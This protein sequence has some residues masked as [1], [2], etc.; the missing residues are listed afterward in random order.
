MHIPGPQAG[1]ALIIVDLQNDFLPGGALAVG[2]GDAVIAPLNQAIAAFKAAGLPVFAG[3]RPSTALSTPSK[4]SG[5]PTA[6]RTPSAPPLRP[7]WRC[8]A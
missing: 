4:A 8:K 2:D 5:R 3:T 6:S 7:R 1:D